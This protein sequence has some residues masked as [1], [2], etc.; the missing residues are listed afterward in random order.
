MLVIKAFTSTIQ[1]EPRHD[2]ITAPELDAALSHAVQ[3]MWP[4]ILTADHIDL[5][6]DASI[7]H[8]QLTAGLTGNE[9]ESPAPDPWR[10]G[11]IV[12]A[13]LATLEAQQAIK[14]DRWHAVRQV[15][16]PWCIKRGKTTLRARWLAA[17]QAAILQTPQ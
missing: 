1:S 3:C 17:I 12:G 16:L 9:R 4:E 2:P 11:Q 6:W 14:L 8:A 10:A 5:L 7:D 15:F 13:F